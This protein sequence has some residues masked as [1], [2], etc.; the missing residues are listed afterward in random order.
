MKQ[1]KKQT[2]Q[3]MN[4]CKHKWRCVDVLLIPLIHYEINRYYA[5]FVCEKCCKAK[6]VKIKNEDSK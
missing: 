6:K 3:R 5:V 1:P 4:E 2:P